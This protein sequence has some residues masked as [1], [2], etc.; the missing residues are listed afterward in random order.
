MNHARN[1]QKICIVDD[2][3]SIRCNLQLFLESEGYFIQSAQ[4][5][6]HF[7]KLLDQGEKFDLV[8]LDLEM[9]EVDGW[10]VIDL[11]R[12]RGSALSVIV[13][14]A[15]EVRFQVESPVVEVLQKSVQPEHLLESIRRGLKGSQK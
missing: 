4:N 5:G 12:A 15:S 13:Y 3:E 14:S 10:K 6:A 1:Q 8:I 2:N 11:L 7:L 9:P